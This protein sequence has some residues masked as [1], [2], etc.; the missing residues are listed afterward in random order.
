MAIHAATVGGNPTRRWLALGAGLLL[1]L[2]SPAEAALTN[3]ALLDTVVAKFSVKA[4][5][6]QSVMMHAATWLFWT[7]GTISLVWTGGMMAL[8][9]ADLGE[10]FAEFIRFILF[11]GFFLWLL[12]N[13]PAFAASILESMQKMGANASGQQSV[14]PSAIVD[15]GFKIWQQAV[16]KL[17]ILNLGEGLVGIFMSAAILLLL[18][19]VAVNMLLLLASGWILMYAGIFFLGFGGSRWT[20][21]MAINYYK[22]VLGVG[23]QLMTMILLVGVGNDLLGGYYQEFNKEANNLNEMVVLLV[24]FLVLLMLVTKVPALVAGMV[25]GGAGASS[26]LGSLDAAAVMGAAMGAAGRASAAAGMAGV[27]MRSGAA[28]AVGYTQALMAAYTQAAGHA[29]GHAGALLD[30]GNRWGTSA[31]AE[32]E[33]GK[34]VEIGGN[35]RSRGSGS[36]GES[37]AHSGGSGGGRDSDATS[38]DEA[39]AGRGNNSPEHGAAD[40][41]GAA[42]ASGAPEPGA[43][44]YGKGAAD[45]AGGDQPGASGFG[46]AL[47]T[48]AGT[49]GYLSRGALSVGKEKMASLQN[50]ARA[51]I[52]ATMGARI[53]S[54]IQRS[55]PSTL[56][57]PAGGWGRARRSAEEVAAFVQRDANKG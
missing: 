28:N 29:G 57:S 47:A 33:S 39:S 30:T 12:R 13:G 42:G 6:W 24:F 2:S 23:V 25:T 1:L 27:A 19:A 20:S 46:G 43:A 4:M 45:T 52:D 50:Q 22:S 15:I 16:T 7:L 34:A 31:L 48:A 21:D 32:R 11:F 35:G 9:K 10:F 44:L 55:S 53:A 18:A 38:N 5:G 49:A 40:E 17:G 3:M 8:R 41:S 14:T 36:L 54:A 56:D 51:R 26:G 37:S